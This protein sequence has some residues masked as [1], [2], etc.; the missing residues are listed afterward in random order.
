MVRLRWAF[1]AAPRLIGKA[2]FGDILFF[3][4]LFVLVG[5]AEG[6]GLLDILASWIMDVSGGGLLRLALVLMWA[7]A[8]VTTFLNAGPTTALFGPIVLGLGVSEPHGLLW[9]ALSLGICAGS[10][11]TITGASAGPV[12]LTK[13]EE[14]ARGIR[15][16]AGS[17]PVAELSFVNYAKAGVLLMFLFLLFSSAY[18]W[19]LSVVT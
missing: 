7:A 18:I 9:W 12:A 1:R 13:V 17:A 14:F 15:A 4:G 11:A 16:A 10:S 5:C 8:V 19:G 6:S 3:V 2:G